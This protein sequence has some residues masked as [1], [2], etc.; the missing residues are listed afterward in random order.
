LSTIIQNSNEP[1]KF[2]V[3]SR[4]DK[5]TTYIVS[6]SIGMCSCPAGENGNSCPHQ[7]AVALKFGISN[8]NFIQTNHSD[9]YK[10]AVLAIGEHPDLC[11]E[12]FADIHQKEFDF[13]KT[14]ITQPEV[15]DQET[16]IIPLP[17]ND[18]HKSAGNE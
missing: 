10:L 14:T 5:G 2:Y 16:T 3:P 15:V 17:G 12:K 6:S 8:S 11:A 18:E 4:K 9:K 1:F 13:T 7:T